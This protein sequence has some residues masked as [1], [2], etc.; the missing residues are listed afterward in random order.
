MGYPVLI[1]AIPYA[2]G[3]KYAYRMGG[4]GGEKNNKFFE[5]TEGVVVAVR[6]LF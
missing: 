5:K 2:H 1:Q 3:A 6:I 4:G